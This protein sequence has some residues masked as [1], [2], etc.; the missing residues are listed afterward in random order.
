MG[1][2]CTAPEGDNKYVRTR[3]SLD[4]LKG[5]ETTRK[6]EVQ[7]GVDTKIGF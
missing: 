2:A 7:M 4:K 5:T 3:F 1:G 6:T